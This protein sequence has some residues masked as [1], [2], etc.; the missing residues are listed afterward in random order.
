MAGSED[1][2]RIT[3]GGL[4]LIVWKLCTLEEIRICVCYG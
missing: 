4:L 1:S 3:G 2:V